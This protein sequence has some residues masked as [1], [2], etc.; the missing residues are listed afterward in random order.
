MFYQ[1]RPALLLRLVT[2]LSRS[3]G[4]TKCVTRS[5]RFKG[6][7]PLPVQRLVVGRDAPALSRAASPIRDFLWAAV[8]GRGGDRT[9]KEGRGDPHVRSCQPPPAQSYGRAFLA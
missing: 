7:S 4:R 6:G 2:R 1:R 5:H 8:G 3:I 9:P